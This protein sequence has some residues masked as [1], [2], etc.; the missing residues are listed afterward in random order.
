MDDA[1]LV[2]A[3][4]GA[5]G[6]WQAGALAWICQAVPARTGH[7]LRFESMVGSSV[8]AINAAFLAGEAEDLAR[9]SQTLREHWRGT[10]VGAVY[11]LRLRR[12]WRVPRALFSA[13]HPPRGPIA[14]LDP[15]PLERTVRQR[16]RWPGIGAA[17]AS[18]AL[19]SLAF[20]ATELAS[21][22]TTAF[23]QDGPGRAPPTAG[24]GRR[25]VAGPLAPE[26]VFASVAL[27]LLFPPVQVGGRWYLDGGLSEQRPV[28]TALYMGAR[29]VLS[30]GLH[31]EESGATDYG[32]PPTWPRVIGKTMNTVLSGRSEPELARIDRVNRVLRWGEEACGAGFGERLAAAMADD[33]AGP[34]V[35]TDA[36]ALRPSMDLGVLAAQSLDRGLRGRVDDMTRVVFRFLE[37]TAGAGDADAL[38]YL[39]FDPGYLEALLELGWEDAAAQGDALV[40]FLA[41]G[42]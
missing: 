19:G 36:F 33:P 12:L 10:E 40:G 23:H 34:W 41:G 14:L 7:P 5:R 30:L 31:A 9:G 42:E 16:I 18:G 1:A 24:P 3:G 29:R 2:L 17:L 26:H 8:G 25:F 28:H 4:G 15:S 39:L 21:G 13:G 35:R 6:A 11:H 22:G 32:L 20:V 37:D 38:S 27:P